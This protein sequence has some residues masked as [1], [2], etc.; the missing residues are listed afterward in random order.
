MFSFPFGLSIGTKKG[1][2]LESE[3]SKFFLKERAFSDSKD[4]SSGHLQVGSYINFSSNSNQ[5]S[6]HGLTIEARGIKG[7]MQE[8]HPSQDQESLL[9]KLT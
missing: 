5:Y 9:P 6:F 2:C 4:S 3:L 1:N 8:M 7:S